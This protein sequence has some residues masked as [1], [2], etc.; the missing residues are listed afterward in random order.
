MKLLGAVSEGS[1]KINED[2]W[3]VARDQNGVCAAW[4]FDGVTGINERNY[5]PA[6]SD[7]AWLV[8]K[9]NAHLLQLTPLDLTLPE[10][11]SELVTRLVGEWNA[12]SANLDLPHDYDLPASCLTLVKR[13]QSGHWDAL[14]LGDSFLLAQDHEARVRVIAAPEYDSLEPKI[15]ESARQL[16]KSGAVD[17]KKLLVQFR[18]EL[19][20]QRKTR[21]TKGGLSILKTDVS[22][23]E[24][25][26]YYRFEK[27]RHMLLCTDGF[28]RAVD[29]YG[30]YRDETLISACLQNVDAVLGEIRAQEAEDPDCQIYIRLKPADDAT[31]VV[32]TS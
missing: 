2:A 31:A 6:A 17:F 16:R 19:I 32:L 5:L 28:Y 11:L 29:T 15:I 27:P 22:T 7:A 8:E 23:L 26:T 4:V 30:L 18:S 10:I 13:D 1:G 14:R 12:V 24:H 3:G 20:E 21:N 9:A 25:P